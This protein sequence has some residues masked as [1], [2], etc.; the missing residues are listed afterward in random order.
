MLAYADDAT[1]ADQ[2]GGEEPTQLVEAAID[3]SNAGIA[4]SLREQ[5]AAGGDVA[6]YTTATGQ[7]VELRSFESILKTIRFFEAEAARERGIRRT[8]VV[9][10]S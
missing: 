1:D 7:T 2:V 8:R 6:S 10:T 5:I 9:F 3:T 4:K